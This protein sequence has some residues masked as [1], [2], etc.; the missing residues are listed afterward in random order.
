MIG[1]DVGQ[2]SQISPIDGGAFDWRRKLCSNNK[3]ALV[4]SGM[5]SQL[6]ACRLRPR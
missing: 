1:V 4:A 5:G 3:L 2:G 6:I